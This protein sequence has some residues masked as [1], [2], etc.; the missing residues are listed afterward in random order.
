MQI[1]KNTVVTI[2]YTLS[3]DSGT[4]L[5]SSDGREPLSYLHGSGAIIPG[6]ESQLD[7]KQAGEQLKVAVSPEDGYGTRNESLRQEVPR[8]HF[9]GIEGFD[10]GMRFRVDSDAGP[11]VITVLEIAEDSVT[12]D[13]N[14]P[15]AGVN[16]NFAV[17]VRE[18]REATEEELSHGHVHSSDGGHCGS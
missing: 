13:G 10:V 5:D 1:A 2:D 15:L 16:L 6:L 14:H 4:V 11:M 8:S 12:V 7:G 3:D 17:T 18:V 9:D